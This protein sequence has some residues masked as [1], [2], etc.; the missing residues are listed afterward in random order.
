M[1]LLSN[2]LLAAAAA[3]GV[4]SVVS[5]QTPSAAD[6]AAA[7]AAI[8]PQLTEML[9]AANAHDTDRHLRYYVRSPDLI[10]AINGEP[11]RGY[12]SLRVRQLGWWN[13]GKSDVVYG[14][15]G[16]PSYA[17][18]SPG[19]AIQNYILSS[20]RSVPGGETREGR[21][22]VTA[23]W[24]QRAEGWR[25]VY[26]EETV[27]PATVAASADAN[28]VRAA[29]IAQNAAIARLDTAAIARFWTDD[30][31]IRRGLGILVT[32][33]DN[34]RALFNPN[35]AAVASGDELIFQRIPDRV[36]VSATWPL[37]H[38]EGTWAGH[39]R[40]VD[41]PALISGRYAAQ[42]VKRNG[43]WLIR[44]EVYTAL[45]CSGKG[46]DSKAAP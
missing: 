11:I 2:A 41:G 31:E 7:R 27:L 36:E 16:Q 21:I 29:R 5:S 12:D 22:A 26:A 10:F 44:G 9:A 33:R 19:V 45:T 23:I 37:A 32:G 17:S 39:S 8:A 40:T 34:Y 46:C 42:W 14:L 25:I 18:P 20:R 13:N 38:E 4:T 35:P 3:C 15:E 30:V 43:Q 28:A 6:A 24:Q 1:R